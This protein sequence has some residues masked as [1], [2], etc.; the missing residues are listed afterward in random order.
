MKRLSSCLLAACALFACASGAEAA[1]MRV[2]VVETSDVAAYMK[3][4]DKVRAGL[5][6][7][8]NKETLRFW[9]AR[10]AGPNAGQLVVSI[11]YADMAAYAADDTKMKADADLSALLKG[12]DKIRKI[13]SDSIY[14]EMK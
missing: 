6:R 3:E 5:A 13:T 12:L 1:V 4:L 2:I 11:E 10:F 9:R 14:D 7:I 8:G